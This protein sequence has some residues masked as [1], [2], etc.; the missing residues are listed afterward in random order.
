MT[1]RDLIVYILK[2]GLE[3]EPVFTRNGQLLGF[4]TLGEAAEKWNVGTATILAWTIM[5]DVDYLVIG[6]KVYIPA[7]VELA[8]TKES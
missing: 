4:I 6:E 8:F 1:G 2:N 7:D 3:D 5:H